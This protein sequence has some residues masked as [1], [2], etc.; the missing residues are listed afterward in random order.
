M[1]KRQEK[2]LLSSIRSLAFFSEEY[3]KARRSSPIP[4]LTCNGKI[5]GLYQ[6]D[7]VQCVN[8]GGDGTDVNWKVSQLVFGRSKSTHT[9]VDSARRTCPAA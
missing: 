4:Q 7:A 9:L 1:A 6:P 3:T 5:C 2:V 8:I